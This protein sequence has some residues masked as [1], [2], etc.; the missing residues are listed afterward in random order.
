MCDKR[1]YPLA[2]RIVQKDVHSLCGS[3]IGESCKERN[4]GKDRRKD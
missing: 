2:R 4:V 1:E 3:D